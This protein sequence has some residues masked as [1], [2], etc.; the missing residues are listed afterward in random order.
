[1]R[2]HPQP[3]RNRQRL[4]GIEVRA[5]VV[6]TW[7]ACGR[8]EHG[9]HRNNTASSAITLRTGNAMMSRKLIVW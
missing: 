2:N 7:R 4:D 9:T 1:V 5:F 8:C 3:L 6:V